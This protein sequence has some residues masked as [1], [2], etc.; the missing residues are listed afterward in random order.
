[1]FQYISKIIYENFESM[2]LPEKNCNGKSE[3]TFSFWQNSYDVT[4]FIVEKNWS[5]LVST[6]LSIANGF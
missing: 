6:I 2:I 4:I 1:M 5:T 3:N